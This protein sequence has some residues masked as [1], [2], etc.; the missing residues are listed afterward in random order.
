MLFDA[1]PEGPLVLVG[2][3]LRAVDLSAWTATGRALGGSGPPQ[4]PRL[5]DR[6]A[7]AAAEALIL[8]T[9]GAAARVAARVAT[10]RG[11]SL[12]AS[13]PALLRLQLLEWDETAALLAASPASAPTGRQLGLFWVS[14]A[15]LERFRKTAASEQQQ[16]P[17]AAAGAVRVRGARAQRPPRKHR[18]TVGLTTT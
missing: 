9:P 15:W 6:C 12:A 7:L 3:W 18:L 11:S 4:S 8:A 10:K 14:H 13:L 17:T 1:L 2:S 5:V 16:S